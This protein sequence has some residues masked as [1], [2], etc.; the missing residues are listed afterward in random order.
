MVEDGRG[1]AGERECMRGVGFEVERRNEWQ[2]QRG[3]QEQMTRIRTQVRS[4]SQ[5]QMN[6]SLTFIYTSF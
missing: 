1:M 5:E 2:G 4:F 3:A 6:S